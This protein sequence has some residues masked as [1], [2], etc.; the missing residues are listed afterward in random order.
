MSD[1]HRKRLHFFD[2]GLQKNV[3]QNDKYVYNNIK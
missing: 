3:I 2:F 1:E